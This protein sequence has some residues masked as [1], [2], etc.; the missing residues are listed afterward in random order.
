MGWPRAR[1][2]PRPR[3]AAEPVIPAPRRRTGE[4]ASRQLTAARRANPAIADAPADSGVPV[5][6]RTAMENA[7]LDP[8]CR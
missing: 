8:Y 1:V 4:R 6:R 2:W 7:I 5:V 3:P